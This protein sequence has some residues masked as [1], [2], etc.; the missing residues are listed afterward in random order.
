MAQTFY[1]L[2]ITVSPDIPKMQLAAGDYVTPEFRKEI[3]AWLLS[4]FGVTNL[5]PDGVCY[6][7]K[8]GPVKGYEDEDSFI[9]NPRTFAILK[10]GKSP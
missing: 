6:A 1:G 3:D 8:T 5:V 9:M 7:I 10:K 4:F 2:R